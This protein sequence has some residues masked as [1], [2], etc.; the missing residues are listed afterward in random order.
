MA[1]LQIHTTC[2]D[3]IEIL[4]HA[5]S[6]LASESAEEPSMIVFH[7]SYQIRLAAKVSSSK[8]HMCAL[9]SVSIPRLLEPLDSKEMLV[10]IISR[11]PHDKDPAA[12]T[13]CGCEI[14]AL[15]RQ[16]HYPGSLRIQDAEHGHVCILDSP[17]TW[18]PETLNRIRSWMKSCTSSHD[19]CAKP[20][21]ASRLPRRLIDVTPTRLGHVWPTEE[22]GPEDFNL[23]SLQELPK[24]RIISS[25]SLPPDT[26][27][28]TLSHRWGSPPS[29]RLTKK[30]L[31]LLNDDIS[32]HLLSCS[33]AAVFRHAIHVTRGLGFR[34]IWIDA[35]CIMQD[36]GPE[37]TMDIM[38]M[39]EIYSNS[40]L[41][42]SAVEGK[43][44]EGLVFD[45][46][47][48][49]TNP[50][51]STVRVL[52]TQRDVRLQAYPDKCFLRPSEGPLNKRGWVFQERTLAT[53]IVHFTKDQVFWEC[54][55][56]EASEVLPQGVPDRPSPNFGKALRIAS[57]SPKRELK[58]RW[59][60]VVEEYSNTSLTFPNDRLLAVSAVAKQF[61]S[62]MRLD[63]S[64]YLAGMW[65]DDLPLSMLW[66]QSQHPDMSG[67]EPTTSNATE[68]KYAPSWSWASVLASIT[69]VE[70]D[71]LIA[72]ADVLD[73]QI[74]RI[75][76]NV[77]DG[78][79]FC[80]IRLR[81]PVCKFGRRIRDGA[82]WIRVAQHTEF[83]E[84][85]DFRFQNGN[86]IIIY[87]DVSREVVARWLKTLDSNGPAQPTHCLLHITTERSIDGPLER[88]IVLRRTSARG[89]Y[90]RIGSFFI[91][92]KTKYPGSELED[93]F[94]GR[95]DTLSTDDYLALDSGGKYTVDLV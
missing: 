67:A 27:Y 20:R 74:A 65:K 25:D 41:N 35:L 87:W 1:H 44:R 3:C 90:T 47:P 7:T 26:P 82:P 54:S 53:R 71:S 72:T 51:R 95:L 13:L 31:F 17:R 58:S 12:V 55:S 14:E 43:I 59:Y 91:P 92:F 4:K 70:P 42:I 81:G 56:L 66:S 6:L 88:G 49:C 62:A 22:I 78:A 18:S 11:A 79:D 8:C 10:L 5:A 61:C 2:D 23:L 64:E 21:I 39:D 34:Y 89:T 33:D 86:T 15:D 77:F 37:K 30:T 63:P 84:F 16:T 83:Q 69:F 73:L 93:A 46:R 76:P 9:L 38:Q 57:T 36:N 40:M 80:Q 32:P 85:N 28:L 75:S 52:T 50:C 48:L 24:V 68:M 29:I 45:R 19:N 94:N 60:Q